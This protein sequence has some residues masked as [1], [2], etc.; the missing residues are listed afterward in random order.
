MSKGHHTLH[1]TGTF[2]PPVGFTLDI[3]YDIE[4]TDRHADAA[5]GAAIASPMSKTGLAR[6]AETI[7]ATRP[8]SAPEHPGGGATGAAMSPS[9]LRDHGTLRF[10]LS[11][12]G[13]VE[14]RLFDV[15]GRVVRV[16]A[17]RT[18]LSAGAHELRVDRSNG[19]DTLAPGMYFYSIQTPEGIRRGRITIVE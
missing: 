15:S 19:A 4:V 13:L 9:P 18:F 5:A 1:F 11:K 7:K 17:E 6:I 10:E 14:A 3:T 16:L 12:P 8:Q 2:G